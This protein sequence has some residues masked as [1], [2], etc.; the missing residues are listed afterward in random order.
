G[1][2]LGRFASRGRGRFQNAH[3]PARSHLPPTRKRPRPDSRGSTRICL[4]QGRGGARVAPRRFLTR[5]QGP[6]PFGSS[7]SSAVW[8]GGERRFIGGTLYIEYLEGAPL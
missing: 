6:R 5:A 4:R 2:Q 3:S 7:L 1:Y 8:A